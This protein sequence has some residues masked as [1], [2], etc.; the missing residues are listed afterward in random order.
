MLE[1]L[2]N[3]SKAEPLKSQSLGTMKTI[4]SL[5]KTTLLKPSDQSQFSAKLQKLPVVKKLCANCIAALRYVIHLHFRLVLLE[6]S[7]PYEGKAEAC[8]SNDVIEVIEDNNNALSIYFC[9]LMSD[10][11]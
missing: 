11:Y 5:L 10:R 2:W 4:V 6:I 1:S 7:A 3:C 9:V 8:E